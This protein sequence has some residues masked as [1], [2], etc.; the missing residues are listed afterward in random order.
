MRLDLAISD[1]VAAELALRVTGLE[2]L[3][4]DQKQWVQRTLVAD[5]PPARMVVITDETITTHAGWPLRVV[6]VRLETGDGHALEWRLGGFYAFFEHAAVVLARSADEVRFRARVPALRAALRDATPIWTDEVVALAELWDVRPTHAPARVS[7][8]MAAVAPPAVEAPVA[9][10]I[11]EAA[12][13]AA[14]EAIA[15]A[16]PADVDALYD[17]GQA[18]YLRGEL[19]EALDCWTRARARAPGDFGIAKK[20]VQALHGLARHADAEALMREVRALWRASADPAVQLVD[21]VV[22]D[23]FA[24]AGA[25]VHAS[26]TLRPRDPRAYALQ[27]FRVVGGP[28]IT[29]RVETSDYARERGTPYVLSVARGRDYRVV[30][31]RAELPAYPELKAIAIQLITAALAPT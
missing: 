31:T 1:A 22:V 9:P 8:S 19:A 28:A 13:I 7:A 18:R 26:E 2:L 15:A 6:E 3:P 10:A 16:D 23:Q 20:Q 24:V 5:A 30:G 12:T 25:S 4:D 29:V 21:E 14:W 17:A 27:T 11:V